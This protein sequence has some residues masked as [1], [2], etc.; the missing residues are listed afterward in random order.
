MSLEAGTLTASMPLRP[1]GPAAW[2]GGRAS[3]RSAAEWALPSG[4]CSA[5]RAGWATTPFQGVPP[6]I[7]RAAGT[8]LKLR[9]AVWSCD[10]RKAAVN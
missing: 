2:G 7:V 6:N 8:M 1:F 9:A 5:G 3:L 4:D 10:P